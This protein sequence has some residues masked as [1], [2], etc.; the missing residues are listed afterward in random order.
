MSYAPAMVLPVVVSTSN[1]YIDV[2]IGTTTY[3]VTI[4]AG[5]YY[6]M[7]SLATAV[8]SALTGESTGSW[9][10][11]CVTGQLSVSGLAF[12]MTCS[13]D[14]RFKWKTGAHAGSN[15]H[16]ILGFSNAADSSTTDEH[17][18][19]YH[20]PNIWV[21]NRPPAADSYDRREHVGGEARRTLS[22]SAVKRLTVATPRKRRVSFEEIHKSRT[23]ARYATGGYTNCDFETWWQG[24]V[25]AT[26][27]AYFADWGTAATAANSSGN[28]YLVEPSDLGKDLTRPHKDV[29]TYNFE[30][31]LM[32]KE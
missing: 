23:L 21:S 24:A 25:D 8:D 14:A 29:E 17:I 3:A 28:Y 26:Q 9:T 7:S 16:T 20:V 31:E 2:T 6:S 18:G 15:A 30:L 12:V 19:D 22:G 5:T 1:M 13:V 32:R 4:A 27:L 10:I 11:S